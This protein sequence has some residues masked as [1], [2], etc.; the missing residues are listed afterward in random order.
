MGDAVAFVHAD[1]QF[2]YFRFHTA[3]ELPSGGVGAFVIQFDTDNNLAGWERALRYEPTAGTVGVFSAENGASNTKG[4][5]VS[6]LAIPTSHRTKYAGT[7]GGGNVAFALSRGALNTAGIDLGRPMLIGTTVDTATEFGA[8]LN[9]SALLIFKAKADILG[10]G[11]ANPAW[12]N[13]ASDPLD[14]DSDGDGITDPNDNCPVN[15]NPGQ[16]DDDAALEAARVWKGAQPEEFYTDD[17]HHPEKM[18]EHGEKQISDDELREALII[19]SDPERHVER[20]REAEALGATTMALMNVS[21]AD[22]HRAIEVYGERVLPA[23]T[24]AGA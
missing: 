1:L 17:W 8:A 9:A 4:T 13:V 2:A 23:L 19:S 14:I 5:L 7:A 16:E 21:G 11:K 15:A 3:A 20:I 10:A 12:Q 6:T 24:G 22:P 18:Y